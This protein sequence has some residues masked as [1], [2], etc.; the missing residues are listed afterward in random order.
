MGRADPARA[1]LVH[2]VL[3]ETVRRHGSRPAL[4][5]R[6][7]G[8]WRTLTWAQYG[9]RVRLCARA[10]AHLGLVPGDVV[11][12]YAENRPEWLLADVGAILAGGVPAGLYVTSPAE[13]C[14]H[15]AR[16]SA[17]R[18][19]V[20]DTPDRLERL[21]AARAG[22]PPLAG[23]VLLDG[24]DPAGEAMGWDALLALGQGTG[25]A[26]GEAW[27]QARLAGQGLDDVC[28]LIYTSGTTGAPKAVMLSHANLTWTADQARRTVGFRQ[29][30]T[31]LSYLPLTHIAEQ[32][33]SI[34]MQMRLGGCTC[35]PESLDTVAADLR[36]VRPH[37]FLGVP[38]VWD[39]IRAR[40]QAAG[41]QS[42]PW[43][44]RLVRWARRQ[45]LAGAAADSAGRR[46]P[47]AWWLARALVFNPVRRR[48]GLQRSRY[49]V[50]SSTPTAAETLDFFLSLGVPL[51][52]LYGL[53]ETTGPATVSAP[54]AWRG[55]S[56]GRVVP[57]TEI[58]LDEV[59]AGVGAGT[60]EV[61][62]RGPHIFKGYY[63]DPEAT[64]QALDGEGWLRTGDI[65]RFDADGYLWIIDR[66]RNLIP[67]A[68]G[69]MTAPQPLEARL[70]QM[71][72]LAQAV[73]FG[74]QGGLGA[75]LFLDRTLAADLAAAANSPSAHGGDPD[76]REVAACPRVLAYVG[77]YVAQ[78]RADGPAADAID[79]FA[80]LAVDLSIEGGEL[81][82]TL[83]IRRQAVLEK[84]GD[85]IGADGVGRIAS[86]PVR[87]PV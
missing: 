80:L 18:F 36:E 63:K 54:G 19:A 70:R 40:M 60:G 81:T 38:R 24:I 72:G 45:G 78:V 73:V 15:V 65:G 17:A 8:E 9:E 30:D 32:L 52:D 43:R 44:A 28:T 59:Q 20:V 75:L 57:G 85:L 34:H 42:G 7:R 50:T 66:C 62:I 64:R 46:R 48:L 67:R 21:R 51:Y 79:R 61:L 23:L 82:A 37:Y 77:R 76:W 33:S 14:R 71:P 58:R 86:A 22:L 12:L 47:L 25:D 74:A 3:A 35:F 53:C 55:G 4:R 26:E 1:R 27:L 5:A 49:Q 83:K 11:L 41:A 2:E 84:Y 31:V 39:G 16:H 68:G 56:V 10:L 87:V 69:G 29:G 13:H 6:V